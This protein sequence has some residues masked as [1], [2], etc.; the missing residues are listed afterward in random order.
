[1]AKCS[2]CGSDNTDTSYVLLIRRDGSEAEMCDVCR[3]II[4][5]L[6]NER[7]KKSALAELKRHAKG[8]GDY[9]VRKYLDA[10]IASSDDPDSFNRYME[11]T[12][13]RRKGGDASTPRSSHRLVRPFALILLLALAGYGIFRAVI[14]FSAGAFVA[15]A[16]GIVLTAIIVI[17][18]LIILIAVMDALDDVR[19]LNKHIR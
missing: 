9:E 19:T 1:M 14:D 2:V 11:E 10:V 5:D 3:Q 6:D 15:G 4:E 17:S 13:K 7:K 18:A 12:R 8:C 16:I